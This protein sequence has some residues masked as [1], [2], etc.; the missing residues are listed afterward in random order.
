[1][2]CALRRRVRS[3]GIV[4]AN[5]RTRRRRKAIIDQGASKARPIP[6]GCGGRVSAP[7]QGCACRECHPPWSDACTTPHSHGGTPFTADLLD[8]LLDALLDPTTGRPRL[9]N[10]T[11]NEATFTGRLEFREVTFTGTAQFSAVT[12]SGHAMF[13]DVTFASDAFFGMATFTAASNFGKKLCHIFTVS[14]AGW[15]WQSGPY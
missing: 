11:F 1:M 4:V 13:H 5:G 10:A 12:F 15:W 7:D 2:L 3:P 14:N 9:G 6:C 8:R